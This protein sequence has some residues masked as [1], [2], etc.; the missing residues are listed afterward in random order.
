MNRRDTAEMLSCSINKL[1]WRKKL[2]QFIW[3]LASKSDCLLNA[4]GVL[5][6]YDHN[7]G[8][9]TTQIHTCVHYNPAL[10]K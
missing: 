9:G 5:V 2:S 7:A 10:P 1:M 3:H 8:P 6:P 4:A